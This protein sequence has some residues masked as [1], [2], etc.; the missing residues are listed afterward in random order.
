MEGAVYPIPSSIV[1]N[2]EDGGGGNGEEHKI[3]ADS[4]D[5]LS[6]GLKKG[7]WT[8]LS[9]VDIPATLIAWHDS[10]ICIAISTRH[11]LVGTT[12][13]RKAKGNVDRISRTC[14]ELIK[15]YNE[16]MGGVDRADSLRAHLTTI[17]RCRKWWHSVWYWALDTALINAKI[18]YD[19][20]FPER[21]FKD[22]SDFMHA[23]V[24]GLFADAGVQAHSQTRTP[25]Y[26]VKAGIE[27]NQTRAKS[28]VCVSCKNGR[29]VS[30]CD[31]C[32]RYIHDTC[33][34]E[35]H[36]VA[37]RDANPPSARRS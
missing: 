16:H 28:G 34:K 30:K 14:P 25:Q 31:K 19:E 3:I 18:L 37:D 24:E 4:E 7:E 9:N 29:T 20:H 6:C 32:L 27:I 12:V 22:R 26:C 10:G 11:S 1:S 35:F 21:K 36:V 5:V 17:R 23:I 33:F 2:D 13:L 8:W 15:Y